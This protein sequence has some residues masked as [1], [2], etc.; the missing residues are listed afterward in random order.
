MRLFP[1]FEQVWSLLFVYWTMKHHSLKKLD[2]YRFQG[3]EVVHFLFFLYST[4]CLNC[5][6]FGPQSQIKKKKQKTVFHY[7]KKWFG[8]SDKQLGRPGIS[9]CT[10]PT[11]MW[12]HFNEWCSNAFS[13]EVVCS[14]HMSTSNL[15]LPSLCYC[16]SC[17]QGNGTLV[18][19]FIQIK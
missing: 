7:S 16:S 14:C 6:R 10:L 5:K 1:L 2:W 19:S 9:Y 4:N 11:A 18:W 15:N 17:F 13:G 12:D 3:E 8:F